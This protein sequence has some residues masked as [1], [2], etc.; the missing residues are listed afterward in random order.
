MPKLSCTKTYSDIPF[1]HRQHTHDGHCAYVHGHNWSIRVTFAATTLDEN[2]FVIDFGKLKFLKAWIEANLD[3]AILVREDDPHLEFFQA[4]SLE[5][6]GPRVFKLF[7]VKDCSSEG[8]ARFLLKEW[9]GMVASMTDGRVT[10]THVDV[11]EDS[12][13]YA[14]ARL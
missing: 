11:I 5:S 3:H 8:L 4:N 13:N 14:T 2:G 7:V 6:E 1:A 10:V 9:G 12:K